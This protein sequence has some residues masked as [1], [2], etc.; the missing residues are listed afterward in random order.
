MI[1]RRKFFIVY[2]S[3]LDGPKR[4][5]AENRTQS[6]LMKSFRLITYLKRFTI[7]YSSPTILL[8]STAPCNRPLLVVL[9]FSFKYWSY[10]KKT[11]KKKQECILFCP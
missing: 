11:I 5:N 1:M 2:Y 4:V 8:P 7:L 3:E 9:C 6:D 10:D